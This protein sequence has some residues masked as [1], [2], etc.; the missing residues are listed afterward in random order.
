MMTMNWAVAI[1][2][3]AHHRVVL[4]WVVVELMAILHTSRVY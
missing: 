3:R 2:A 1:R 4:A